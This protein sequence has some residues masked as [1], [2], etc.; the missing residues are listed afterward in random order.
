ME[1]NLTRKIY[2]NIT[3]S[4]QNDSFIKHKLSI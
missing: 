1:K 3:F 2:K 4:K